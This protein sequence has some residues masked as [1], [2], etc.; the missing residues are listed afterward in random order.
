MDF[1][2]DYYKILE[3]SRTATK[4]EIKASYRRQ[5]K[6][7]HPDKNPGNQDVEEKFKLVN[8]AHEV[9]SNDITRYVYDVYK[10]QEEKLWQENEKAGDVNTQ[11][12]KTYY[13]T[14]TITKEKRVYLR[15]KITVK[16]WGEQLDEG[17]IVQAIE[18]NYKIHPTEVRSIIEESNIHPLDSIPAHYQKSF[19][20]SDLFKTPLGQPIK[21][22]VQTSTGEEHYNLNLYD[23]R[24]KSPKI[25]NVTKHDGE[26][27][28][29]LEGELFA[30][31]LE[32]EKEEI[33]VPV[34]ECFGA[35]G[36]EETKQEGET[37]YVRKEYYYKDCTTYWSPW[38]KVIIP[39]P[40]SF[41]T[42]AHKPVRENNGCL[43][44][45]TGC[46]Q[47]WW[48][49]LLLLFI[50]AF[51]KF[52]LALLGIFLIGLLLNLLSGV[53]S[54]F[55]RFIS[56]LVLLFFVLILIAGIRSC[57]SSR[58]TYIKHD[59]P[60][61]DTLST[62]TVP[63]KVTQ[64][65]DTTHI[66]DTLINHFIR[67]KDYDST[68]YEA[69]LTISNA[70]FKSS[71]VAHNQYQSPGMNSLAPVYSYLGKMDENKLF[72]IYNTFDSIRTQR[73][74]D[75]ASFAGMVVSCIQSIPFYLVV[76]R[77]CTDSYYDDDYIQNY[78]ASCNSDCCIGYEKYGVR[79]PVEFLSDLKGD[80]D[81]RSL[82]LYTV[83]KHYNY[84]VA[85]LTSNYY[86]HAMIA[87]NF[88]TRANREG[89]TMNIHDHNYYLWETTSAGFNIG[90]VPTYLQNLDY[91]EIALLNEN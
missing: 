75:E 69:N 73:N 8:E 31:T 10:T 42:S 22:T 83:L 60:S 80:C 7:Y 58:K 33:Q 3:L 18:V 12:K 48:V 32:V 47:W 72:R 41:G 26:S 84:N 30:Y 62:S 44:E 20:E 36:K 34:T 87:V 77:S 6:E 25:I 79:S 1:K 89:L 64:P 50:I 16:F 67:W 39:K 35:T 29:T 17:S 71:S 74:L 91:W 51:P 82:L 43:T 78:L 88:K 86:K 76:D 55:G 37:T 45:A 56:W 59:T 14:E 15:G 85:L 70:D 24:V 90:S 11:N 49:P 52:I 54:L 5:A 19:K 38:E 27:F 2:K 65:G 9:L 13:R 63:V 28:G 61:Y 68:A 40:T 81:T 23:I 57:S 21:C 53:A 46:L 4:E 66:N